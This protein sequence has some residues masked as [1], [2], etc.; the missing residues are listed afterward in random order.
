MSTRS[1]EP[2]LSSRWALIASLILSVVLGVKSAADFQPYVPTDDEI[3][4]FAVAVERM[5]IQ[6]DPAG[7][8]SLIDWGAILDTATADVNVSEPFRDKFRAEAKASL[9]SGM[10]MAKRIVG[11]TKKGGNFRLLR[12]R[13][14]DGRKTVLFR[15]A[16]A[17]SFGV[18]YYEFAPARRPNGDVR[19]TDVY[20]FA[21]GAWLSQTFRR[22]Y[23]QTVAYEQR[24][25][26]AR[27]VG[28]DRDLVESMPKLIEMDTLYKAGKSREA[29]AVYDRLPPSVQKDKL[30]LIQRVKFAQVLDEATYLESLERFRALHPR[31]PAADI[32]A[33]DAFCLSK[34]YDKAIAAID[35]LDTLVGGDPYLNVFRAGCHLDA[36]RPEKAREAARAAIE[37]MPNM[38]PGYVALV[39]ADLVLKDYPE[40]LT[41]LKRMDER[42]F[43]E[44]QDLTTVPDYA[45]FVKSPQFDEWQQYLRNKKPRQDQKDKH[46][47]PG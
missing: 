46:R 25:V 19:A 26:I 2:S 8:M 14:S 24:G 9:N 47:S 32:F 3:K 34:Q 44:F 10:S 30:F 37:K 18:S 38:L 12:T 29:L 6:G 13:V 42:S 45:G 22:L 27:L 41:T 40:L 33:A 21:G 35:R 23:L 17:E 36:G 16:I 1:T 28:S 5:A 31:D 39:Q 20:V 43:F 4:A 11:S 15:H 7:L